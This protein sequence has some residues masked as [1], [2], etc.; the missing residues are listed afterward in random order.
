MKCSVVAL[1]SANFSWQINGTKTS[2]NSDTLIINNSRRYDSG[3]YECMAT[4]G[5]KM[6]KSHPFYLEVNC[7]FHSL[8]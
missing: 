7:K 3:I 4:N 2:Y 5:F 8:E 6:M 1:P